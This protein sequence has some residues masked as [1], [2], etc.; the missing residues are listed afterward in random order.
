M[1]FTHVWLLEH[2]IFIPTGFYNKISVEN[3]NEKGECGRHSTTKS[4]LIQL[5]YRKKR[6]KK[7]ECTSPYVYLR[8]N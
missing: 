2:W 3:G 4:S 7:T 8:K 1:A 5:L 6:K